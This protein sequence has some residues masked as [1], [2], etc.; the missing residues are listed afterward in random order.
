MSTDSTPEQQSPESK[1]GNSSLNH[2]KLAGFDLRNVNG[3][4]RLE[5]NWKVLLSVV[6]LTSAIVGG[7]TVFYFSTIAKLDEAIQS[8]E[9]LQAKIEKFDEEYRE[10]MIEIEVAIKVL[11]ST[12]STNNRVDSIENK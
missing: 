3:D 2:I 1:L 10:N 4:W 8:S 9:D 7:L 5:A 12:V 6:T 11:Q